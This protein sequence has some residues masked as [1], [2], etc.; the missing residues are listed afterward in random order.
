MLSRC[1]FDISVGVGTFVIG[2]SQI[3]SFFSFVDFFFIYWSFRFVMTNRVCIART[4]YFFQ[5]A[6]IM[7]IHSNSFKMFANV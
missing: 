4:C 1:V 6:I 3:S 2:L 7:R 5:N